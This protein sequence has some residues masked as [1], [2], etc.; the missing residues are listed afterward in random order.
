[1]SETLHYLRG[2]RWSSPNEV[3]NAH[4]AFIGEPTFA[5]PKRWYQIHRWL[6]KVETPVIRVP[7]TAYYYWAGLPIPVG[8]AKGHYLAVGSSGSG[9][10]IQFDI[11]RVG[12]CSGLQTGADIRI[13][14]ID[15]KGEAMA[16]YVARG[17]QPRLVDPFDER[18]WAWAMAQDLNCTADCRQVAA[19]LIP[20]R[21]GDKDSFWI[22]ACRNVVTGVLDVLRQEH[23]EECTFAN[24][25]RIM[26]AP[27][28][29]EA[30]LSL[31]PET[32]PL[33]ESVRG[34]DR[35]L[36]NLFASLSSYLNP[37]EPIAALWEK[38][39]NSFSITEWV[40][41]SGQVLVLR[42]HPRFSESLKPIHRL[43]FDLSAR[44]VLS[45][46]DSF[47]RH[48]WYLADEAI[49]LGRLDNLAQAANLGR[50]KGIHLVIGIQSV[51]GWHHEYGRE[52]GD[53]ILGQFR[54][55]LYL[56]TDSASTAKWIE[57][58]IGQI[59][60]HV[61]SI[62]YGRTSG[63]GSKGGTSRSRTVAHTHR[64]ESLILA[65]EILRIPAP[66]PGGQLQLIADIADI[67]LFRM[68]FEFDDLIRNLGAPDPNT[69]RFLERPPAD[70][71][72]ADF[73]PEQVRRL[74]PAVASKRNRPRTKKAPPEAPVEQPTSDPFL[75]E[76]NRLAR[77][78]DSNP[79]QP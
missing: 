46:P 20:E 69:P 31:R 61:Q 33:W 60:Y 52:N 63:G 74:L 6:E 58:A 75:D 44:Q 65:S 71:T 18:G 37:F 15:S 66:G 49:A 12:L 17:V 34:D 41:N 22:A 8:T 70:Q 30:I 11:L 62:T 2:R 68:T 73:S 48:V 35:T 24:F 7:K 5:P 26:R 14:E 32:A 21:R 16:R 64:R 1:M 10:S 56:R 76:L 27:Q 4:A 51:E 38:S 40:Q 54:N 57:E 59:E 77:G 78:S 47:Q 53:Q 72:L 19:A 55:R 25:L 39:E 50:S 42:D 28:R 36:A 79:N 29:I 13:L 23:A 45:L 67:G 43:I 9:K 3:I